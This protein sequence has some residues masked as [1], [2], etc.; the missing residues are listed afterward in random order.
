MM[1]ADQVRKWLRQQSEYFYAAGFRRT[2]KATE[3]VYQ[4]WWRIYREI[5]FFPSIEYQMVYVSYPFVTCLLIPFLTYISVT[6]C[7]ETHTISFTQKYR[8]QDCFNSVQ[9]VFIVRCWVS[10]GHAR[11]FH[12]VIQPIY[13]DMFM[14]LY[15]LK[16]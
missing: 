4:C 14:L 13:N 1:M 11:S 6:T 10:F 2:G 3:Q 8:S 9:P 5:K 16:Q 15:I 7:L 12:L